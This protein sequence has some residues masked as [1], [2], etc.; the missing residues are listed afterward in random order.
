MNQIA[1]SLAKTAR[2]EF[3]SSVIR[4]E[5]SGSFVGGVYVE[6]DEVEHFSEAAADTDSVDCL[7]FACGQVGSKMR[8]EPVGQIEVVTRQE[9]LCHGVAFVAIIFEGAFSP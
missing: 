3:G 8:N 5:V 1:S 2:K 6:G 4:R 9:N 7:D